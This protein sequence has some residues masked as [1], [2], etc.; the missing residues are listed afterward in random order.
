MTSSLPPGSLLAILQISRQ[1]NSRKTTRRRPPA[2]TRWKVTQSLTSCRNNSEILPPYPFKNSLRSII[3]RVGSGT[4][5][6][7]LELS[8]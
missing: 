4:P 2:C 5:V 6:C 7:L 1:D 8:D 3:F